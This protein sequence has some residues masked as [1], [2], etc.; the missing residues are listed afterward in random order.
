MDHQNTITQAQIAAAEN[1]L[2]EAIKISDVSALDKMLHEDLL[3]ITPDGQTVTKK[4]DLDS[5]RAGTMV[6]DE[7][8]LTLELIHVI[9]NTAVS[10]VVY[11]AKG[12]MLGK[13]LEGT[14]RYL[15]V[16]R[17]FGETWQVIGG[18]CTAIAAS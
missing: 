7:I 13:P 9:E 17:L 11:Q 3:F 1:A 16:W 6:V 4:M 8:S 10:T 5:H 2:V 15:R 18:S 14:F 12:K